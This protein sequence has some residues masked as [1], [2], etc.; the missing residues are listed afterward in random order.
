MTYIHFPLMRRPS[1]LRTA[2]RRA[3]PRRVGSVETLERRDLLI[4]DPGFNALLALEHAPIH[5]QD[6][7][8]DNDDGL[9]GKADYITSFDFDGD[10]DMKNNWENAATVPMPAYVYYSVAETATHWYIVYAFFHTRDWETVCTCADTHENDLEGQ[11]SIVSK[12]TDPLADPYGTLEGMVTTFHKDFYSYVAPG[13]SW[14]SGDQGV[15]GIVAYLPN[16]HTGKNHPVTAQQAHGH[17]LKAW[18]HVDIEGGDGVVYYPTLRTAEV[19]SSPND[20]D[21][22]YRLVDMF[23]PGGLWDHRFDPQVFQE[24][25]VFHSEEGT[26]AKPV[27]PWK[28]DDQND[29]GELTGGELAED[30]AKLVEIYFNNLDNSLGTFDRAYG[31]NGYIGIDDSGPNYVDLLPQ[32]HL[33]PKIGG[34]DA[35]FAGNG[36]VVDMRAELNV[37]F[38]RLTTR[39]YMDAI[40]D[41]GDGTRARGTSDNLVAYQP[42]KGKR[43][44]QLL[45]GREYPAAPTGFDFPG[46]L[47]SYADTDHEVDEIA[48]PA[49]NIVQL[50]RATGDTSG[51]EAG[52]R[53]AMIAY[54]GRTRVVLGVD[55][56]PTNLGI[57]AT[58][59]RT[60]NGFI[61]Y[62]EEDVHERFSSIQ[63]LTSTHFIA[64]QYVG[65]VWY[66]DDDKILVPFTPRPTDVLI[67][68]VDFAN[69]QIVD[70]VGT[71]SEEYGIPKG[72]LGG[73]LT[74]AADQ[75]NFSVDDGEFQIGGTYFHRNEE[76]VDI[77]PTLAGI[78]A[79]DAATGTGY[80]L[81]SEENVFGRFDM[82]P[83]AEAASHHFVPVK[84]FGGQWHY[85]NNAAYIAFTPRGSDALVALV[86]FSNDRVIDL[87]GTGG[88][89][90][91]LPLGYALGDLQ[92]EVD[93]YNGANND[94]EFT[95][96]GRYF[97]RNLI[98]KPPLGDFS[99]DGVVDAT[100]IDLMHGAVGGTDP[101][102]DL[103][104]DGNVN[105]LDVDVM[106]DMV[107][108]VRP[109]DVNLNG[110]VNRADLATIVRNLGY[111]GAPAW[112]LGDLDGNGRVALNDVMI[113][114]RDANL[115]ASPPAAVV[116]RAM[117]PE[118]SP[119]PR[120][121]LAIDRGVI[122]AQARRAITRSVAVATDQFFGTDV[123]R[124]AANDLSTA[125]ASRRA[126]R[127][128]SLVAR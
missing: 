65:G 1:S 22:K 87:A 94:G 45:G 105:S 89:Y 72:Y 52:T 53:T 55:A 76:P 39:L 106:L 13:S 126:F 56:A 101:R 116:A 9:D 66:Y 17:G 3:R 122:R 20:R 85:D 104:G 37:V 99:G 7:A 47:P 51:D 118:A 59:E 10:W 92:L 80:L 33:P 91:G 6:T 26:G 30:P 70:L 81:Y 8:N 77:G 103:T 34:G 54:F 49:G 97:T 71:N 44:V 58:D 112:A 100:D 38:G 50:F 119:L 124:S 83:S 108:Q 14:T 90:Q 19:P 57:L 84:Y 95:V 96:S 120:T 78:A 35:D 24:Y 25:G 31:V 86:D 74:F 127:M 75:Y 46:L 61:L 110:T 40:E 41:G 15:D 43:V 27:T 62:S 109:G 32:F 11:L 121:N 107:M 67:A 23:E 125:T 36:P 29:G 16:P 5:Y 79:Q 98:A 64:V 4:G 21:V 102:F 117:R 18:P 12:P 73:D 123:D 128:K 111:V 60:G 48:V 93:R 63:S 2:S 115:P 28:W 113:V 114:H 68:S 82:A 88:T 69:D 42:P